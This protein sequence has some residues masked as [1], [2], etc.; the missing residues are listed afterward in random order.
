MKQE[1]LPKYV[2]R[3]H[4]QFFHVRWNPA[5]KKVQWIPLGKSY[6]DMLR[7]LAALEDSNTA[8]M[9]DIFQ[10]YS[11]E[12][13]IKQAY[14]TQKRREAQLKKLNVSFGKVVPQYVTPQLI[15]LYHADRSKKVPVSANR[16]I[17]LL[18]TIFRY[19][20]KWGL[21]TTNPA[22][23]L[24]KNPEQPRRRYVDDSELDLL[25]TKSTGYLRN[26]IE[27]AF[28][29]GQ[30]I[31]DVLKMKWSDISDAG[32]KVR[33]QKTGRELTITLTPALEQVLSQCKSGKVLGQTILANTNGQ[34]LNYGQV[35]YHF[36]RLV[37]KLLKSGQISADIRIHDLRAK[38]ASD[39]PLDSELLGNTR[40]TRERVYRRKPIVAA[41]VK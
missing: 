30:R 14:G 7:S 38:S 5:V 29:T 24:L 19:A 1:H 36:K 37:K 6:P 28:L 15:Y 23:G 4:G 17:S 27:L 16:E 33:Q 11:T 31:N 25:L 3:S 13:L 32:L 9:N 35:R 40:S 21:V 39:L 41:P 22:A 8:L 20:I 2:R 18:S 12:I 26:V 10:R 34:S